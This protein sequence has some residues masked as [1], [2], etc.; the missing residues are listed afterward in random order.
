MTGRPSATTP[1]LELRHRAVRPPLDLAALEERL[2]VEDGPHLVGVVG[3]VRGEPPRPAGGEPGGRQR[4][5]LGG[6]QP[7]LVVPLLVP[8]V[9]EER[10]QLGEPPG[11]EQVLAGTTPRP[12]RAP[13]RSWRRSPPGARKVLATPGR[14]TSKARM[15]YDGRAAAIAATDSPFAGPDLDDQR[16]LAPEPA[17]PGRTSARRPRAPGPASRRR[18]ASQAPCWVGLEPAAPSR[19]RREHLQPPSVLGD[20][21][22]GSRRAVPVRHQRSFLSSSTVAILPV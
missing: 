11:R 19:V 7:S 9:G 15:S 8:R 21:G 12:P 17:R 1:A 10:P 18:A 2:V 20:P 4:R 3:P 13:G 16:R 6:D 14:Q 22:P 5:E